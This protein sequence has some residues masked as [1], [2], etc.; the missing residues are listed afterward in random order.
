MPTLCQH[1]RM[2]EPVC[3]QSVGRS[4]EIGSTAGVNQRPGQPWSRAAVEPEHCLAMFVLR[5]RGGFALGPG[6]HLAWPP[7][8]SC[9]QT[10]IVGPLFAIACP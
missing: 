9:V 10:Y 5:R 2:W 3:A 6:P 7:S 8:V 1:H 4:P